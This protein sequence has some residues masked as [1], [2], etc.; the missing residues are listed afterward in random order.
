MRTKLCDNCR[1]RGYETGASCGECLNEHSARTC[2]KGG[3]GHTYRCID[4][5]GVG[6][7]LCGHCRGAGVVQ[8]DGGP[9]PRLRR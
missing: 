8:E 9:L 4:C 1:A 2:S 6:V 5:K 3:P 7:R